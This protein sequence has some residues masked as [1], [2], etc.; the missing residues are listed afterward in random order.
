MSVPLTIDGRIVTSPGK[1]RDELL[2]EEIFD[3][4][5]EARGPG[6]R[7]RSEYST[8]RPH[9]SPRNDGLYPK[10]TYRDGLSIPN[11]GRLTSDWHPD[12]ELVTFSCAAGPQDPFQNVGDH[13]KLQE[14]T[15]AS[16]GRGE[17]FGNHVQ[18][19]RAGRKPGKTAKP[20]PAVPVGRLRI[21]RS[22]ER[23]RPK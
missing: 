9:R 1:L 23:M 7:Y 21:T 16:G 13:F 6:E 14:S 3:T 18:E 17:S 10:H 22:I 12:R 2:N 15:R 19:G 8:I 11:G 4:S 20:L 5:L